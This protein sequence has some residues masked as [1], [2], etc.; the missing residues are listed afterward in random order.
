MTRRVSDLPFEEL[1]H[2]ADFALRVRGATLSDLFANAAR[3]LIALVGAVADTSQPVTRQVELEAPDVETLLVDW[4]TELVYFMEQEGLAFVD[5]DVEATPAAL[6]AEVRGGRMA[7]VRR[8]VKAVTYHNLAV[9]HSAA[10][11][12][13]TLVFDV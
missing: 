6:H 3:G 13:A 5:Y 4:L 11:Y 8:H 10:G 9:V 2:T 12:E 7:Q 1:D